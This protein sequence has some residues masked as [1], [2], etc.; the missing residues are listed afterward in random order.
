MAILNFTLSEDGVVALQNALTC[1]LRFCDDVSLDATKDRFILT[2]LNATKSAHISFIFNLNR[3]FSR[4]SFEGSAQ[5]RDRFYCV[6][7]IRASSTAPRM[8]APAA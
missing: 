8:A 6:L 4:Y 2:G 5:Y 3:F 1:L 7:Y